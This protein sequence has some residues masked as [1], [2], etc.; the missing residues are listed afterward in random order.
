MSFPLPE[1][2][3]AG[4]ALRDLITAEI[5]KTVA[6]ILNHIVIEE[7]DGLDRPQ[8]LKTA[9]PGQDTPW[10]IQIPARSS[11]GA[12][13]PLPDAGEGDAGE[14]DQAARADHAHPLNTD[15]LEPFPDCYDH[16][17]VAFT[18]G[19]GAPGAS[20]KYADADH[21]HMCGAMLDATVDPAGSTPR[22]VG[23]HM[24]P[25]LAVGGAQVA[26]AA[27]YGAGPWYT[28]HD[29]VHPDR[30]PLWVGELGTPVAVP[31]TSAKCLNINVPTAQRTPDPAGYDIRDFG[32][33]NIPYISRI[34]MQFVTTDAGNTKTWLLVFQRLMHFDYSGRLCAI[35]P[36]SSVGMYQT[37]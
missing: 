32:C 11:M 34:T 29:H 13:T 33:W 5:M 36:E 26:W 2:F 6:G 15:D 20:G 37:I 35:G 19:S 1:D 16:T 9:Q 28:A 27:R 17:L 8:I 30:F 14:S 10:R 4:T 12:A 25:D 18:A 21:S 23:S 24:L 3:K 31:G 22:P 7:V